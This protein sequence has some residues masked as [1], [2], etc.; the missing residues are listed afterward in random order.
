MTVRDAAIEARVLEAVD[1]LVPE[2]TAH[3]QALVR[4]PSPAGSE[5]AA[6]RWVAD[7]MASIGLEVDSFDV[8]PAV[9][10]RLNT[11][12]PTPQD[13]RGRPCVVGTRRGA[14]GGRSL[15]FNAHVD[16]VPV[17]APERWTHPA[18]EARIVD[19]R[20]YGRGACDD[21]AGVIEML[22]VA[23]ALRHAGVTLK[24]NLIVSSVIEDE[25][26]GNGTLACV[27]R[28]YRGDGVV[29]VDGTWPERFI[30]SHMGQV[31]FRISLRGTA[32]HATSA[33]PNPIAAIGRTVTALRDFAAQRN[34]S[35]AT[36]WG[37]QPAPF[38]VNLGA[39]RAGVWPGSV[40]DECVIEG[41]FGFPPPMT[42]GEARAALAA[43]M[44]AVGSEG[45]V[46][47]PRIEFVGLE[48][49]PE[50]GDPRNPIA[51]LLAATV[52]R[53]QGRVLQESVIAGHCDLRHY[54]KAPGGST[55]AACLYGPGGGKNVHGNDEY[56][57]LAHLPVVAGNLACV[58]LEWCGIAGA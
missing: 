29:I 17:D 24:G 41:Q 14:G 31:S 9:L 22:L 39:V 40:P 7:R 38:F 20:L 25:R 42:C 57:E 21:K 33:G 54:T 55:A 43:L 50:V 37:A 44:T 10:G 4:I 23:D 49:P 15:V 13:Y 53:R 12:N 34:A 45:L 48:T 51:R 26:T 11:F 19:G 28:G 52:E 3:L 56:F 58:A 46:E 35:N 18:F 32:G 30:V 6:Q 1:R 2:Y 8:D 5:G 16:T 47:T 36:A 27:E